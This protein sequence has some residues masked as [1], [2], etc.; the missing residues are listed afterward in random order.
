MSI[1][2]KLLDFVLYVQKLLI[3]C[4]VVVVFHLLFNFFDDD[5]LT[6]LFFSIYCVIIYFL[7]T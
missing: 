1:I 6:F 7:G 5:L 2:S 3:W 4:F